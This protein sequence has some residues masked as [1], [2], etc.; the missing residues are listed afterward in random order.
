MVLQRFFS[1][2]FVLFALNLS[3]N[4]AEITPADAN[5]QEQIRQQE[6]LRQLRQQQ[7]IKPDAR[8]AEAQLKNATTVVNDVIPPSES[9]C[10]TIKQI[11]LVGELSN[12]FQ[13]ALDETLHRGENGQSITGLCLGAIGI[14]AVMTRVQNT[15]RLQHHTRPRCPTRYQYWTTRTHHYP[16]PYSCHTLNP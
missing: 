6:R 2:A 7:E 4:A 11:Q 5:A 12:K 16:W 10:F 15:I 3:V 1:T 8:D 13:F 14:N 9:P